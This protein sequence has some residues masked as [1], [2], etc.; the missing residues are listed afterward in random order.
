MKSLGFQVIAWIE[1]MLVHGPGDIE[2]SSINLDDEFAKFIIKCY[3]VDSTGKKIIRRAVI[4]R[5]KGRAKS[6]LSAF[7]AM[8]E[9]LGP[10]R[11]S[12]WAVEGEISTH[13]YQ[14]EKG[15]PV[16]IPVK[17]PEIICLATELGQ[18]DNA[19]G[20][21]LYFC[22]ESKM[23][24][25]M[26]P[27]IEAGYARTLLP[28]GGVIKPE[29][30]MDSSSDGGK[31]SFSIFDETH[32][33]TLPRLKRLHQVI[34]RNSLKRKIAQPWCLETTTMFAPGNGSTAEGTFEYA[35]AVK[36]GRTKDV[37]LL[38]DHV[39]AHAKYDVTK[40]KDRMAG[41]TQVYGP[42]S[43]WMDL[44]SIC[45]SYD[46]PQVSEAEWQRY[47]FNRPVSIQGSWLP[48]IAWDECFVAREI[49]DHANVVLSLDGSFS[50]DSTALIAVEIGEFPHIVLAGIWEKPLG[51]VGWTVPILDVEEKIRVCAERW[52]V[53]EVTADTHL[54]ARSLEV[55]ESEGL[56]VVAFP[57]SAARMTPATNRFQQLVL[58]RQ[59]THSG[60]PALTRH[61]SNAV[62]K[63]DSRGTRIY[64]E[65]KSSARKIDAA[66]AAI[67]GI[68]RC[69]AF[70]DEPAAV[71]PQFY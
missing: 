31:Q 36:E 49:P 18:A 1:L 33:W 63:Q 17:R 45:D 51:S 4:S 30:A 69:F 11:F 52:R 41:L 43:S 53:V 13:G 61:I 16:G 5:S 10:V 39:E 65:N 58:E 50:Q 47:W 66:V 64:K 19:Y 26:Y 3:E 20:N 23:L 71:V 12:H 24:R 27:G 56:P 68:E 7:I 48:A 28:N 70:Q 37:G 62:L 6:E 57:Q 55:L 32:L 21:I 34:L 38:F 60:D 8:A 35:Q 54:W 40:K 67:M 25:E 42:A 46:D 14:F 2:G 15:E 59:L 44:E 9:A 22:K 29:T